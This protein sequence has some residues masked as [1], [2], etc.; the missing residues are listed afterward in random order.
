M[1]IK[2]NDSQSPIPQDQKQ[3]FKDNIFNFYYEIC[4]N[5]KAVN[6]YK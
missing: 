2:Y 4:H 5:D 1:L 3:I 6:L